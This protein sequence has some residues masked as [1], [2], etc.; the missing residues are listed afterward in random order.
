MQVLRFDVLA[1]ELNSNNGSLHTVQQCAGL[2]SAVVVSTMT[3]RHC[4]NLTHDTTS[5]LALIY[6]NEFK[7]K[8]LKFY[9]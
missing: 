7:R 3:Y 6:P 5:V 8:S 4:Y 2:A 1:V 9:P